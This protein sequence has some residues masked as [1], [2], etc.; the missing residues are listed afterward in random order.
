MP[1]EAPGRGGNRTQVD[2]MRATM[3]DTM[4]SSHPLFSCKSQQ[5]VSDGTVEW[6]KEKCCG[7]G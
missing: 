1:V 5:R 4:L 2:S 7:F 3:N 6:L